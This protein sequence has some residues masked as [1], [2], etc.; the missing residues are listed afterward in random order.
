MLLASQHCNMLTSLLR[1]LRAVS[2]LRTVL[3]GPADDNL[4]RKYFFGRRSWL[5][6]SDFLPRENWIVLHSKYEER[7]LA[8]QHYAGRM[9]LVPDSHL[10]PPPGRKDLFS[11]KRWLPGGRPVLLATWASVDGTDKHSSW[12]RGAAQP[13][14]S[15]NRAG[16]QSGE[17]TRISLQP[18]RLWSN[19]WV[20]IC[21][22][23]QPGVHKSTLSQKFT[24]TGCISGKYTSFYFVL[25]PVSCSRH[26]CKKWSLY[27]P[28]S[29]ERRST[30]CDHKTI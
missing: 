3:L 6:S 8:L 20:S 28:G 26:L 4:W 30:A 1:G 24:A 17:E 15:Q 19:G 16:T 10:Q 23:I 29:T 7:R 9:Q 25:T 22:C 27:S 14:L 11:Q 13:R 2:A 18:W 5:L 21:I 12:L